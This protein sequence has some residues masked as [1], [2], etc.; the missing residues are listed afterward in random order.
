VAQEELDA[1]L[2]GYE[3]KQTAPAPIVPP[4]NTFPR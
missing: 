1:G 4:L 2:V 3:D